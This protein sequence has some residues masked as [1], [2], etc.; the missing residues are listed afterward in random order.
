MADSKIKILIA[1]RTPWNEENSFGNT[2]SNLFEG[3]EDIEI[4]NICCQDGCMNSRIIDESF[5]LT[6][7]EVA[8][9]IF[10]HRPGRIIGNNN[11]SLTSSKPH[12]PRKTIFYIAREI[13]WS[14]GR[15]KSKELERFIHDFNPDILY[16][17]IYRSHY[18][19]EIDKYLIK[20]TG[21]PYVVHISDDVYG[22]SPN[23]S[24]FGKL[25]QRTIRKDVKQ[26]FKTAAYG[27]VF[28]PVMAKE[29]AVEFKIPFHLIGKSVDSTRLPDIPKKGKNKVIRFVYTG[30]YGGERGDQLVRLAQSIDAEFPKGTAEI[31]IYS[32][33]KAD[34]AIES[35]LALIN[36]VRLM[37][38][39]PADKILDIQQEADY[40]IHVEGFTE[41]AVFESRLSFSTKIID[42]L[43][44][45]RPILAIGPQ[46]VTSV[47]VLS[48]YDMAYVA[49]DPSKLKY[50]L[51][52]ISHG[53]TKDD[54]KVNNGRMYLRDHRDACKM[55][56]DMLQRFTHL[57]KQ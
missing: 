37:G 13:I 55:K 23:S 20:L 2:F 50:I 44:A 56:F 29:Y 8:K 5:Q 7:K 30:N 10:G 34:S 28:S 35:K 39:V 15:W 33:T 12:V 43:I 19:C 57:T 49:T 53:Q 26:I 40:L 48:S 51:S 18:M 36:C 16:L 3:I 46:E 47:Q 25:L 14:I 4:A 9:S 32:A 24:V 17:P 45:G 54:I 21:V 41:K 11:L 52:Q 1:S 42:Y 31:C 6:D 22:Y 38:A 27:E